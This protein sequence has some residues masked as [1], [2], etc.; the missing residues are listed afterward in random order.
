VRKFAVILSVYI[1]VVSPEKTGQFS[2]R[3]NQCVRKTG[4]EFVLTNGTNSIAKIRML[5]NNIGKKVYCSIYGAT[6]VHKRTVIIRE[7]LNIKLQ[8]ASAYLLF[9]M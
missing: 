8:S 3:V 7:K 6:A 1:F 4:R 2:N 9:R 5:Q